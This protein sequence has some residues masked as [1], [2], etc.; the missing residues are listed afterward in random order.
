MTALDWAVLAVYGAAMLWIGWY[1]SRS[2]KSADDYLLGGRAMKPWMVGLS[3]FATFLSV[4]SFLAMPGEMIQHGPMM[5]AQVI[6]FPV[7]AVLICWLV[8][9]YI[10]RLR[11]TSG[12][13]ILEYRFGEDVRLLAA[14]IFLTLRFLWM[15]LVIYGTVDK[16]FVPVLRI[17]PSWVPWICVAV[18]LVT[19]AYS[20]MGGLRAV[21][22]S[23]AIQAIIL[24]S[25]VIVGIVLISYRLGGVG[26]WWPT[27]WQ[28][29][30]DP[31][32]WTFESGS[33]VTVL[34][35][36]LGP[37]T[38]WIANATSDQ[39]AIQRY[40]ATR[41][42]RS[43]RR[44][45][46]IAMGINTV[47]VGLLCVFGF[48]LLGF[49]QKNPHLMAAGQGFE[50]DADRLL[51]QFLVVGLPPGMSGLLIAALVAAAMSSLSSGVNSASSVIA[52]DLIGRF[53]ATPPTERENLRNSKLA[54]WGVGIVA[55]GLSLLAGM[56]T[57]NL[58]EL[59]FKVANLFSVPLFMLF[60]M[61]IFIP[62]ATRFGTYVAA[63]VSTVV[64]IGIAYYNWFGLGF[65]WVTIGPMIVGMVV[66][67][68]VSLLPIGRASVSRIDEL[69][70]TETPEGSRVE[71]PRD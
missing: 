3:M 11:V 24:V 35:A 46:G 19:V 12:Y 31:L 7:V 70:K 65:N 26:A 60:F 61:A 34:A 42:L 20:S 27:E 71:P 14:V 59:C 68:I 22:L 33:R 8:I 47:L 45:F 66:G 48:A 44:M 53:R 38:F 5:L 55:I 41:D 40:L 2:N 50:K 6:A 21:V 30:W 23:D 25:G 49:F 9:P 39:M 4:L 37:F 17:D 36:V 18:G 1:Y 67:P 62:W 15:G 28:P 16:V 29:H 13:E 43:A 32:A 63:A 58:V 52:V 10:M 69:V 51:P 56:I 57:G 54:S 64:A